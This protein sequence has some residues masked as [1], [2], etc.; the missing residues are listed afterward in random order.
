MWIKL[1]ID[2]FYFVV[3]DLNKSIKFYTKILGK[4]PS[5]IAENR[6]ADWKI[7]NEEIYFGIIST[8]ATGEKTIVGN[9]GV[10][11]L[12]T[13]NIERAFECCKNIG[14]NIIYDIEK[15]PNSMDNYTC[16]AVEDLDGNKIEISYYDK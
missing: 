9:N 3:K 1:K 2:N 6:W 12:Y 16:F 8:E 13:H 5:N 4:E 10:L 11:G 15:L 7:D 14:A